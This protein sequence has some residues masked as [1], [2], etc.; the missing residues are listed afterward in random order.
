MCKYVLM[1][2]T[3]FTALIIDVN[4]LFSPDEQKNMR[5]RWPRPTT[6]SDTIF[7]T[8]FTWALS[9]G[10]VDPLGVQ[11]ILPKPNLVGA[12]LDTWLSL[13]ELRVKRCGTCVHTC[14]NRVAQVGG[15]HYI[16]CTDIYCPIYNNVLFK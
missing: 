6:Q 3:N 7:I 9:E 15:F 11:P 1:C 14:S 13:L 5:G 8:G 10:W 16:R 12:Y 2:T 4:V